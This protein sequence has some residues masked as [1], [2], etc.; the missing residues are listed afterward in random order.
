[1]DRTFYYVNKEYNLGIL[2]GLGL[3][4]IRHFSAFLQF[5]IIIIIISYT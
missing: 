3:L 1:M 5:I 4:V 2:K